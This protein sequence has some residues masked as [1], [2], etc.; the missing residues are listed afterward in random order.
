MVYEISTLK[1]FGSELENILYTN[2]IEKMVGLDVSDNMSII[3]FDADSTVPE[4]GKNLI[5][6]SKLIF[7]SGKKTYKYFIKC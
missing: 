7:F 1:P 4:E 2:T 5:C 3:L 6:S